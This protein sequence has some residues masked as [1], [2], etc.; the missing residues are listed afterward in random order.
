MTWNTCTDQPQWYTLPLPTAGSCC[1]KAFLKRQNKGGCWGFF[2]FS[3]CK[4]KQKQIKKKWTALSFARSACLSFHNVILSYSLSLHFYKQFEAIASR[5]AGKRPSLTLPF[6]SARPDH[7]L[8]FDLEPVL[9]TQLK[10]WLGLFSFFFFF[11][12]VWSS[13]LNKQSGCSV[14]SSADKETLLVCGSGSHILEDPHTLLGPYWLCNF[15]CN[16][17]VK[18]WRILFILFDWWYKLY[19]ILWRLLHTAAVHVAFYVLGVLLWRPKVL[20]WNKLT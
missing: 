3:C 1:M 13:L 19:N 17:V 20:R 14:I 8:L 16:I 4:K 9:L 11:F 18:K 6:C 2:F 7:H 12:G 15:N 10:M 5:A